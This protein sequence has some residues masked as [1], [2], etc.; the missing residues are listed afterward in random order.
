MRDLA[1]SQIVIEDGE[2]FVWQPSSDASLKLSIFRRALSAPRLRSR[3]MA[4]LYAEEK[5]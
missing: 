1:R 3:L 4:W 2:M 5:K